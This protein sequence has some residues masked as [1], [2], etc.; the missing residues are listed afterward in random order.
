MLADFP[1]PFLFI[2][3]PKTG[4]TSIERALFPV[5]TGLAGGHCLSLEQLTAFALPGGH[6]PPPANER[7]DVIS[8]VIQHESVRYFERLGLLGGRHVF[9]VV[10]NPYDRALSELVYLLRTDG[11]ARKFFTG[12]TWTDDLKRLAD[13]DGYITHDLGACQIDWLTDDRGN[14]R[15]DRIMRFENLQQDWQKLCDDFGISAPLSHALDGRRRHGWSDFYDDEALG[16]IGKKYHRD[17]EAFGYSRER[18][19]DSGRCPLPEGTIALSDIAGF[20][21]HHR[22]E[23]PDSTLGALHADGVWENFNPSDAVDIGRECYRVLRPGGSLTVRTHD[24][25]ATSR[26]LEMPASGDQRYIVDY[27]DRHIPAAT[28]YAPAIALNHLA[29]NCT[30]LYDE[31]MLVETLAEAGFGKFEREPAGSGILVVNAHK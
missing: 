28:A 2:H 20:G 1:V 8:E 29:R 10:R 15:C 14:L 22:I 6:R 11:N 25:G 3:I 31:G 19:E 18:P 9:S 7:P 17:F 24:F 4:G 23:L 16:L 30:F 12:P 27:I 26:L 5:A 13:F 21:S